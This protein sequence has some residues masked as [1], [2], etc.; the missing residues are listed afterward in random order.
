LW[1]GRRSSDLADQLKVGRFYQW[2][3]DFFAFRSDLYKL[4]DDFKSATASPQ[5]PPG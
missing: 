5:A 4:A 3:H 1:D 2:S